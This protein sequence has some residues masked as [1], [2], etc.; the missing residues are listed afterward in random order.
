M[1]LRA[2][3]RAGSGVSRSPDFVLTKSG[4]ESWAESRIERRRSIRATTPG[5]HHAHSANSLPLRVPGA[6]YGCTR[7]GNAGPYAE[8]TDHRTSRP[9]ARCG[10]ELR[11]SAAR[12]RSRPARFPS[13]RHAGDRLF[14]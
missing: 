12:H 14:P 13:L 4:A 9:P 3:V 1:P 5:S 2:D 8:P 6:S 7:V 11:L 10:K